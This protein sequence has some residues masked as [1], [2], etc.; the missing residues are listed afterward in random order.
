M[1]TM[2]DDDRKK[3]AKI[4]EAGGALEHTLNGLERIHQ[5]SNQVLTAHALEHTLAVLPD[6]NQILEA[7]NALSTTLPDTGCGI[8]ETTGH[9]LAISQGFNASSLSC[10]YYGFVTGGVTPAA[11][12]ADS[13]VTLYDQNLAIN[14]PNETIAINVEQQALSMLAQLFGYTYQP[15]KSAA[16]WTM[17]TL[18]TGGTASNVLGLVSAREYLKMS[19]PNFNSDS[20]TQPIDDRFQVLTTLGHSSL[21][22]AANIAGFGA[23]NVIDVAAEDCISFDFEKLIDQLSKHKYRSVVAVSCGEVNT[24]AFATHSKDEMGHL[25]DVC[26][27]YGAW[28]HVDAAF[29]MFAACLPDDHEYSHVRKGVEGLAYADSI[30]GDAHK[31][32]NVPYDCGFFFAKSVDPTCAAFSNGSAPYLLGGGVQPWENPSNIG[33]ENS[34]RFRALPVYSTLR[35]YGRQGY[36]SMIS[37]CV[38]LARRIS[39][40]IYESEHYKLLPRGRGSDYLQDTF[41]IVLFKARSSA[42]NETLTKRINA[43]QSMYVSA[44]KWD[45]DSACRIA[46]SNW[47][48]NVERDCA[49]VSKVLQDVYTQWRDEAN[50]CLEEEIVSAEPFEKSSI[51]GGRD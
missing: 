24:G 46:V 25:R 41:I 4:P 26:D 14:L 37:R 34:R 8:E 11:R 19:H 30:A 3:L 40:W 51:R 45:G 18:T 47:Q 33:I 48:V 39:R 1:E 32:L 49:Y 17:G 27:Q 5:H 38:D 43:T 7:R 12:I 36:T 10:H 9:L 23:D 21:S 22:K 28:L 50:N 29:G 20:M 13:L 42:L 16:E 15:E 2:Q 31:L 44:T 35:A 6:S